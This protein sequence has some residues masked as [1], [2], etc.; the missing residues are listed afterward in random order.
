MLSAVSQKSVAPHPPPTQVKVSHR[1]W[2]YQKSETIAYPKACLPTVFGVSLWAASLVCSLLSP[3][4]KPTVKWHRMETE[5]GPE[6]WV[7]HLDR[8][9]TSRE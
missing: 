5:K 3:M 2:G 9:M 7:I 4:G 6:I 1:E 8:E